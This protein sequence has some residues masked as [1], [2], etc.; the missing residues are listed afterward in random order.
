[1]CILYIYSIYSSLPYYHRWQQCSWKCAVWCAVRVWARCENIKCYGFHNLS[2][3]ICA[4]ERSSRCAARA[5]TVRVMVGRRLWRMR[6][7]LVDDGNHKIVYNLIG[8][9]VTQT[10]NSETHLIKKKNYP[11][12]K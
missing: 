5:A 1:M 9:G 7:R 12:N 10:T 2:D 6:F 8:M 4:A 11:L 3:Y